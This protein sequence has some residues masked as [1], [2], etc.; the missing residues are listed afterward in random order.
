MVGEDGVEV[1]R[2]DVTIGDVLVRGP[3][4]FDGYLEAEQ[5]TAEAFRDGWF[6]RAIS[7]C[8][9]PTA[10]CAWSVGAAPT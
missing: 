7:A 4:L 1:A 3:S 5:A 2:D 9:H 6:V 10:T 8:S